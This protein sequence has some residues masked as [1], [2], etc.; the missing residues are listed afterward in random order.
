MVFLGGGISGRQKYSDLPRSGNGDKGREIVSVDSGKER[1]RVSGRL[2]DY[3]R[4][5]FLY[6]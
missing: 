3:C 5:K 2:S 6:C 4:C 1:R